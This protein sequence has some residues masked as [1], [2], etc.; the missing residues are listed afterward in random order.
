[1]KKIIIYFYIITILNLFSNA[2]GM[3]LI[4]G[5]YIG[6]KP[7]P[8]QDPQEPK[9]EWFNLQKLT[10]EK[11]N[12]IIKTSTRLLKDG[13]VV[14][15]VSSP[16][17]TYKGQFY[18]LNGV[19]RVKMRVVN[20]DYAREPEGGWPELDLEVKILNGLSIVLDGVTYIYHENERVK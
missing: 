14:S 16:F 8:T 11:E 2:L 5:N 18:N 1:M 3:E 15:S 19:L 17:L 9:I 7:I 20:A 6:W 12:L 4:D 10:I 13:V